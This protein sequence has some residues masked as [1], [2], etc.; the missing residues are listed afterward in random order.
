MVASEAAEQANFVVL[1]AMP[2]NRR[3]RATVYS[4]SRVSRFYSESTAKTRNE[5]N[6]DPNIV[7]GRR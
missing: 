6:I 4:E 1:L 3:A 5:F 7:W 2:S